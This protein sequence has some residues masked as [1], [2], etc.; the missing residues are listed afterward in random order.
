MIKYIDKIERKINQSPI[1]TNMPFSKAK[2]R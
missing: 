2:P 1:N